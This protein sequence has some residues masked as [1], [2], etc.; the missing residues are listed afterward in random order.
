MVLD[1]YTLLLI[2]A[3]L[4]VMQTA[5]AVSLWLTH[6]RIGGLGWWAAGLL[7]G[8]VALPLFSMQ[9][10]GGGIV[11]TYLL[12]NLMTLGAI[13]FTYIGA[14][15]F[16][17]V[18]VC[19]RTV[20]YASGLAVSAL[21]WFTW[22]LESRSARGMIVAFYMCTGY[23]ATMVVMWGEVRPKVRRTGRSVAIG[24]G[25]AGLLIFCRF[26][27]LA[28]FPDMPWATGNSVKTTAFFLGGIA[29]TSIWLF[30]LVLLTNRV[31]AHERDLSRLKEMKAE[32]ALRE[33]LLEV[34]AQKA[35]RLR[36]NLARDLH[37]GI[38]SI[39][40]NLA[41]LAALGVGEDGAEREKILKEI[42]AMALHGNREIRSLLGEL[43][44][45]PVD[46]R[47]FLA[48]LRRCVIPVNEAAGIATHWEITG[49]I[50]SGTISENAAAASLAKVL[51]EA[52]HNMVKHSG[53][54]AAEIRFEF[55]PDRLVLRIADDGRGFSET[56][57]DGRGLRNMARRCDDLGGRFSWEGDVEGTRLLISVPLPLALSE[58][59]RKEVA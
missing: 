5:M 31:D 38:G 16:R 30:F 20:G 45:R 53:A 39:T 37:D 21:L 26:L 42:E 4:L 15:R 22:R 9:K 52:V 27:V 11:F 17:G 49:E 43:D 41:L 10:F 44:G 50:P 29:L 24:Y 51:R 34:E 1:A 2:Y 47:S 55:E 40:A 48:E 23:F 25:L 57:R 13:A 33:A 54:Q 19:W 14:C 8:S 12:P 18:P 3:V 35:A 7:L 36:E 58:A 32:S 6:P 28:S 46:W 56:H 59:P